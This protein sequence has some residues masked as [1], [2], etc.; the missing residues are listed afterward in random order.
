[1]TE[2]KTEFLDIFR[3]EAGERLDNMVDCLLSLERQD[4]AGE[5]ISNL[6]RDAHTI[7][8]AAGML[9][10]ND[11]HD[12]AHALEDILSDVRDSGV[13]PQH[14]AGTLLRSIDMLRAQIDGEAGDPAE[15]IAELEAL[16]HAPAPASRQPGASPAA[17]PRAGGIRRSVHVPAEKI[18]RVLDLVGETALHR[19][20]LEYVL[21]EG[22][23]PQSAIVDE[24]D[25]GDRLL[26]ELKEAAIGMRTLPLASVVGS[27]PRAVRDLA[28]AEGK[29]VELRL[30]GIATELDRTILESLPELLTHLLRNAVAHGI[31]SPQARTEAGKPPRGTI[32]IRAEQRG[33]EVAIAVSDDGRGVSAALLE[34]ARQAGSLT[35]VLTRSGYSTAEKVTTLAGRGVGLDAVRVQ[36]EGFGGRIEVRSEPGRGTTVTLVLPLALALLEILLVEREGCVYG[37]PLSAVH[38][39][40]S[41]TDSLFLEGK[42]S[43]NL[44]GSSVPLFDLAD[45]VGARASALGQPTPAAVVALG[46]R[47]AVLACDKLIGQ[48]EVVV[49]PLGLLDRVPTY[50]GGALLGDGRI[51]LLLD[52]SVIFRGPPRSAPGVAVE[53]TMVASSA[54]K[55]LV[56]EDFVTVRELHRSILEAAGYRVVTAEDG[57][58]ALQRLAAD[59]DISIVISDVEMPVMDGIAL[60]RAIRSDSAHSALPVVIMTTRDSPDD[61]QRGLAAGAD[62]YMTKRDFDQQGLLE[63]VE[64]LVGR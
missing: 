3:D 48:A 62:A 63:T 42:P 25:L 45:A 7:K 1:M 51:A 37:I 28:L 20:R 58:G 23:G 32:A 5:P 10:L 46:E 50:V 35:E 15:I 4:P 19:S 34:E 43:V 8:G 52:L 9:G 31:E 64:R 26:E 56:V 54:P 55:V 14:L 57:Q 18:D 33:S 24:L 38:E 27:M 11:V 12:L 60:T 22:A 13:F 36:V 41:V 59:D 29:D 16:R 2:Q 47:R 21:S 53:A 30:D 39:V 17:A 6:F 44:R 40:L 61:R 49:K